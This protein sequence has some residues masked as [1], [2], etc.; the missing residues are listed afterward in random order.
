M[1]SSAQKVPAYAWAVVA[2]LWP[3][4]V[5]NYLDRQ[6]LSTMGLSIKADIVELQSARNFGWFMPSAA[7]WAAQLPIASAANG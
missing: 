7:R 5:L 1:N 2:L 4:V 6:M 3:V